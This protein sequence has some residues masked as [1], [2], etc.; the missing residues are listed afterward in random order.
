MLEGNMAVDIPE[1]NNWL[2]ASDM[3]AN[4]WNWNH[5]HGYMIWNL[6][7]SSAG[8]LTNKRI[9][10]TEAMTNTKGVFKAS[11]ED[12]KQSDD[13]NFITGMNH[14]V[15][16]GFNYS[17]P[18]AGFPGWVRYGT[19]F[20][21][22]NTWWPYFPKW[23][24]Y[25]ARLSYVFQHA[26]A[27][28][29]IAIVAPRDD[30]WANAGLGRTPFQI[31]PWYTHRLWEGISQAGSS[32]DYITEDII[33]NGMVRNGQLLYGPM[34]FGVVMLAS[35]ASVDPAVAHKLA[36][37]VKSGGTV[38]AIDTIPSRSPSMKDKAAGDQLVYS[39][40]NQL[41]KK[42][43]TNFY[44]TAAPKKGSELLLWVSRI[45]TKLSNQGKDIYDVQ[46]KEPNKNVFQIHT[47]TENSDLY[48]FTN[49]N[50]SETIG[51]YVDFPATNRIPWVWNPED[52]TRKPYTNG[53]S[54]NKLYIKLRPLQS[55][56]LVFEPQ[57]KRDTVNYVLENKE[58]RLVNS[59]D[60]EWQLT[61]KHINGT[62]FTR[63]AN[64]LHEF[65]TSKDS[66][67]RS[68]AGTVYYKT[69]FQS[70]GLGCALRINNTN[71]GIVEVFLNHKKIGESWYGV[72]LFELAK[73]LH[74]GEN[75]LEIKY[76]TL[77]S[78]YM[79][80]LKEPASEIW[81]KNYKKVAA[82]IDGDIDILTY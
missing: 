48:F 27:V 16:H 53:K 79:M 82:G 46:V 45:L 34:S 54:N 69:T 1:S 59:L 44:Q 70:D 78:N 29:K 47:K 75:T 14:S 10:S 3:E 2:F 73:Q 74:Q 6:Y 60:T 55:I 23:A 20:S 76:T 63:R 7:A 18:Y 56:L 57:D 66:S 65:G 19:Y 62:T 42:Y 51:Y 24:T 41:A 30:V 32:C 8:H 21:E 17:P 9:I 39:T 43:P 68:F 25:N 72:P 5:Q 33:K 4:E 52:G 15:L 28:K 77:L 31:H 36:D 49:T 38:I 35:V 64:A 61:F 81:T 37:F 40:F 26:D 58:Y 11:L 67:L 50:R 13:M 22:Q 12:I 80:E 71:R